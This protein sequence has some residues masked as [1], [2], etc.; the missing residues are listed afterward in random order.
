[1][2]SDL[3]KVTQLVNGCVNSRIHMLRH[4]SSS[5]PPAFLDLA[6]KDLPFLELRYRI[7]CLLT[8]G[9]DSK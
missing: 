3:A 2:F 4:R 6:H 5:K 8:K 1:M 9:L 7:F